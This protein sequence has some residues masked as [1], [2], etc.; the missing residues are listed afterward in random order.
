MRSEGA[1]GYTITTIGSILDILVTSSI[2]A[3]RVSHNELLYK[4]IYVIYIMKYESQYV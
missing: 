3:M 2:D 4:L 1:D